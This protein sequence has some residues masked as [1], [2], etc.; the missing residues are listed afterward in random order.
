MSIIIAIGP[1][2]GR[3]PPALENSLGLVEASFRWAYFVIA[4]MPLFSS[5]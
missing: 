5:K 2:S 1:V 4:Q 3:M